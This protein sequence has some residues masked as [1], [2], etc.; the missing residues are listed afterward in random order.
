MAVFNITAPDGKKYRVTG[1]NAEGAYSALQQMLS[2]GV[3]QEQKDR[4][5]AAKAGTL[6]ISPDRLAEQKKFDDA[7]MKDVVASTY[8]PGR[9]A[10][11]AAGAAQGGTFGFSDELVA[12]LHALSPNDT[13]DAAL[14]RTRGLLDASRR[15]HPVVASGGEIAGALAVPL[16]AAKMSGGLPVRMVKSAGIGGLLSGLYGFMSGEGGAGE[17]VDAALDS[18]KWG[19]GIGAVIPVAG[20]VAQKIMDRR[21]ASKAISAGGRN[22]PTSDVLRAEGQAAYKAIDDAGVQINPADFK[23]KADDIVAALR[24][25]GLDEGGGALN[26]TPKSARVADILTD[27]GQTN[28]P[29][30]FSTLDQMR[31]KAGVAAADVQ[32]FTGRPTL[33]S[34]LGTEAIGGLDDFVQNLAPGQASGDV[35]AL[36]TLI[37]KARDLWSRMSRSQIV[38]DAIDA[39]KENY[40]SGASSGIRNQFKR[41]LGNPKLSRGFSEAEIAA[42]RRV[43]NGSVPE[44]ILNLLGGGLGQ[45]TAIT[46]GA[47]TGPMGF[48][49]GT[50]AA[51]GLRKAA[52]AATTRRAEIARALIAN[53]QLKNLPVANP[54]TRAIIEQLMRQGTAAGLQN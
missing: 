20:R 42:M 31:R 35:E 28:S 6:E 54:Q 18:A 41:I 17:R 45:L 15:D 46:G 44:Q 19:A 40:L 33:D 51:A 14:Q 2:G 16:G 8:Q 39:G 32:G 4:I 24:K 30:P 27:A 21:A 47:A 1:D 36:K 7:G 50:A 29:I 38:E 48:F 3:T 22:A 53:G 12:G 25:G 26:L 43:V 11:F 9:L 10:S 34:K 49:A 37:P 23:S 5:A 52:E 13:Y